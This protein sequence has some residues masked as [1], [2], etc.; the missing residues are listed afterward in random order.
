MVLR[1][2]WCALTLHIV[3]HMCLCNHTITV[4]TGPLVQIKNKWF[5]GRFANALEKVM[6]TA[7]HRI[8]SNRIIFW[9]II[10]ESNHN[11]IEYV[12]NSTESNQQPNRISPNRIT[13]ESNH[14]RIRP[15]PNHN[16]IGSQP[17][18]KRT[19]SQPNRITTESNHNRIKVGNPWR[20]LQW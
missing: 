12:T 20:T 15:K 5:G 2:C 9:Q 6:A 3:T 4:T 10:T 14:N 19:E 13:T 8:E 16:R 17:N 18:H 7:I 11:R 1:T